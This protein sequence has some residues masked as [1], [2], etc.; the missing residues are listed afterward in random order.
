MAIEYRIERRPRPDLHGSPL[1]IEF[2]DLKTGGYL[3]AVILDKG[4]QESEYIKIAEEFIERTY[5]G[6]AA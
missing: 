4:Y 6:R 1:S 5:A 3:C 2:Y